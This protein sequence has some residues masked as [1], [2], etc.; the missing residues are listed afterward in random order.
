M[1]NYDAVFGDK[2]YLTRELEA[3]PTEMQKITKPLRFRR[4]DLMI[5]DVT[6]VMTVTDPMVSFM[7]RMQSQSYD[8]ITQIEGTIN[9]DDIGKGTIDAVKRRLYPIIHSPMF[10]T[11][12]DSDL[13]EIIYNLEKGHFYNFSTALLTATEQFIVITM[14]ARTLFALRQALMSSTSWNQFTKQVKDRLPQRIAAELLGETSNSKYS[15]KNLYTLQK[16]GSDYLMK[17]IEDLP[18]V[19]MTVEEAPSILGTQMSKEGNIFI[20]ISRQGRKFRIGLLLIT[21]NISSMEPI[22]LANTNTELNM[23][24]GNEIEIR[25]AII[26]ASNNIAGYENEFKVLSR[27]EA[28]LTNSLKNVPLPVKISDVPLYIEKELKFFND[29]EKALDVTKSKKSEIPLM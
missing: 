2:F 17:S 7:Y 26:N 3:V 11:N 8:W 19:M 4:E 15:I 14:V 16:K 12:P 9:I 22:I 1:D 5:S 23:M 29:P 24:L 6:S 10:T 18:V 28:I 13:C 27:G 25:Q 21:Q 20:D